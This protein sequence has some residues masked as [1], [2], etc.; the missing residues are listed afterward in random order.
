MQMETAISASPC[1]FS[2][3]TRAARYYR[4]RFPVPT[5]GIYMILREFLRADRDRADKPASD[6]D[7]SPPPAA[8]RNGPAEAE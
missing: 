5:S 4:E 6:E 7:M 2:V 3:Y 1:Y 8:C